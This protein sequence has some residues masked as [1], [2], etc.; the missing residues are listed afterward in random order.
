M[1]FGLFDPGQ[2]ETLKTDE[3]NAFVRMIASFSRPAWHRARKAELVDKLVALS[4]PEANGVIL[5][6]FQVAEAQRREAAQRSILTDAYEESFR[7][8]QAGVGRKL[9]LFLLAASKK[10]A[11]IPDGY[12]GLAKMLHSVESQATDLGMPSAVAEVTRELVLD[13]MGPVGRVYGAFQRS[14]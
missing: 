11:Q 1:K 5:D 3:A 6:A 13:L 10:G 8:P 2:F 12:F 7:E 9:Q 14:P 4:S